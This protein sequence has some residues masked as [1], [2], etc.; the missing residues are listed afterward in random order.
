MVGHDR[1]TS[2]NTMAEVPAPGQ[3]GKD[4]VFQGGTD[5]S[6]GCLSNVPA[7]LYG[8]LPCSRRRLRV[9]DVFFV[10]VSN[11][12]RSRRAEGS[13]ERLHQEYP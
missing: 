3:G 9:I 4:D 8:T 2:T 6:Q 12:N 10:H 13:Q 1:W 5:E 11:L 7:E